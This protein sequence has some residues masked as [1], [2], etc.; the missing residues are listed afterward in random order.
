MADLTLT[1]EALATLNTTTN[2][3]AAAVDSVIVADQAEDDAFRAEIQALKDQIAAG[4]PVTQAD[5]DE[6][7]AGMGATT[8][9]LTA[10]KSALQAMG[11]S[12]AEPIPP[13]D[14][15]PVEPIPN[16]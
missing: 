8:A 10:V 6:L 1:R 9:T 3:L 7:T 14:I 16:P 13:V 11:S 5:L 2:E 12:P 4:D 15:P